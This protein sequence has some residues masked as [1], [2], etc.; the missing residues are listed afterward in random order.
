MLSTMFLNRVNCKFYESSDQILQQDDIERVV[1]GESE[2][3]CIF[4][5]ENDKNCTR[6]AYQTNNEDMIGSCLFLVQEKR[7]ET[8]SFLEKLTN[9]SL[10]L[11]VS[12]KMTEQAQRT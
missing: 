7:Q 2:I 3:S 11:K 8:M 5:C 1:T 6:I 9:I 10:F 4:K 12:Q